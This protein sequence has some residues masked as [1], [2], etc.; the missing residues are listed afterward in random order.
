MSERTTLHL[1]W[2]IVLAIGVARAIGSLEAWPERLPS[3]MESRRA[4]A[5]GLVRGLGRLVRAAGWITAGLVGLLRD[6]SLFIQ[7]PLWAALVAMWWAT[8]GFPWFSRTSTPEA[9]ERAIRCA[10]LASWMTACAAVLILSTG[11]INVAH[12]LWPIALAGLLFIGVRI[13]ALVRSAATE[14]LSL[15]SV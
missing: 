12:G 9:M 14:V 13:D 2:G 8:T 3:G 4:L 10:S 15:E 1:I 7:V 11:L 6:E 5:R